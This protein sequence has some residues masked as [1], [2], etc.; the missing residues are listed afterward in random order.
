MAVELIW[1]SVGPYRFRAWVETWS[2]DASMNGGRQ[3]EL[4]YFIHRRSVAPGALKVRIEVLMVDV[5]GV[6]GLFYD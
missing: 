3:A 1:L 4:P 5:L 6:F 2:L